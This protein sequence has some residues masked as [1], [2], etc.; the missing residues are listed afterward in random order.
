MTLTA[1][2]TKQ[3]SWGEAGEVSREGF[4]VGKLNA[5]GSLA[6]NAAWLYNGGKGVTVHS[7][8]LP[9]GSQPK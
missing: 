8:C 3:S 2:D 9:L 5:P 1:A 6:H 7:C 4:G